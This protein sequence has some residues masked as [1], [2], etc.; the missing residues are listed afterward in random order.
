M[1]I[2]R[3]ARTRA[4]LLRV[5]SRVRRRWRLKL[6]VRGLALTLAGALLTFLVSAGSLE[7]LRF[8]PEM[9]VALRIVLWLVI[10]FC[11]VRWVAWPLLRPVSDERVAL[12]LEE[13]EP[14]LKSQVMTAVESARGGDLEDSPLLTEVVKRAVHQCQRINYGKR[15]EERSIRHSVAV[16]GGLALHPS[17]SSRSDPG[18]SAMA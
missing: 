12:Y 17:C 9:I 4:E 5:V 18:S 14:S 8:Q 1:S 15:I 3:S 11:L 6:L 10:A 13:N 16:L 7:V 2:W